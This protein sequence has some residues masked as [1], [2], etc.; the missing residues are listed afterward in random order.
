MTHLLKKYFIPNEENEYKPH[1]LR[2]TSIALISTVAIFVFAFGILQNLILLK[3]DLISAVIPRTLVDLAN[4]DRISS[5]NIAILNTS[6]LLEQAAQLKANDMATRGY[7]A[8]VSPD[9]KDP[10]YWFGQAGYEFAYA[11]ENLAVN[12]SE[13]VDVNNAWINSPGHK[14][15][16][17]NDKFTEIGIAT[18]K[19]VYKGKETIF[20]VQMFG[21][22]LSN[23]SAIAQSSVL[24]EEI[25]E[26]EETEET[27]E[28]TILA[29]T[30]TKITS[31][32][33]PA[34]LSSQSDG[35]ANDSISQEIFTSNAEAD[36]PD[37]ISDIN[38]VGN[39]QVV[40]ATAQSNIVDRVATNP[41]KIITLA[42]LFIG[43]LVF[44]SLALTIFI[45]IKKQ[46]IRH[47]IYGIGV[48]ALLLVLLFVY[49]TFVF[50]QVFVL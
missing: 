1:I 7:F 40:S 27:E 34:V 9:G 20:V 11:G 28:T 35:D 17:L 26:I 45:E 29:E 43:I 39:T 24:P 10:W 14:A 50:T 3:T 41:R 23:S 42:Y 5:G 44:V 36:S 19:G 33:N 16:I 18:A 25:E 31:A 46:H 30:E 21:R 49:R 2:E 47:I 48:L 22:P 37:E 4:G 32:P 12:F 15:N 6:T 13:S 38:N 8:H